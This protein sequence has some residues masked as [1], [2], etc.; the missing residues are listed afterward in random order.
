[1]PPI[2]TT[3]PAV[4]A[5]RWG[6]QALTQMKA[7]S[8]MIAVAVRHCARSSSSIPDSRRIAALLTRMSMPPKWAAPTATIRATAASS[9]TSASCNIAW[10]PAATISPTT[11]SAS[12]R[13]LRALT[14]MAAPEA[15]RLRAM[16]RPILR[17]A[18]V[19]RATRPV[20]SAIRN[21]LAPRRRGATA[22]QHIGEADDNEGQDEHGEA[23]H[24]NSAE[25]AAFVEV[26]DDHRD[27]FGI[28]RE[29]HDRGGK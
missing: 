13:E 24:G 22:R 2:L 28:G 17:E 14:I 10:P 3:A 15:A 12:A 9:V 27:D 25:I 1:M 7:L 29:Q 18:P 6:R 4:L 19:T 26:V 5:R 21:P 23:E 20:S 8:R 11:A 16:A